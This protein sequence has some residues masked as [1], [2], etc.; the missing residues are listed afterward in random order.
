VT[1]SAR[2]GQRILQFENAGGRPHDVV[3][4][5]LKPGKTIDDM[6]RWDRDRS[7]QPPFVY[8]GGLTPMSNGVT[9]QTKLVLQTGMHVVFCTMRHAGDKARDYQ[10]GVLSS[11]KVN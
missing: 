9:A 1:G 8:V 6:Q 2:P 4:G 11:F 7:D 10:R 5:R 3:V